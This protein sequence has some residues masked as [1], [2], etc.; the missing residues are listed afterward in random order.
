V[1]SLARGLLQAFDVKGPPVPVRDMIR[2]P[3]PVFERLSLLEISLGLYD[4][5]YR[6]LLNGSRLI[7]VDVD[8]PL[9]VQRCAMARELYVAFC[10]SRRAVELDWPD[11]DDPRRQCDFFARCLLMPADWVRQVAAT[12]DSLPELAAVFGVLPEMMNRRVHELGVEVAT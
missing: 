9:A 3:H 4:A 10:C 2:A 1:E 11:R 7:A 6:S 12:V 5:V 8:H